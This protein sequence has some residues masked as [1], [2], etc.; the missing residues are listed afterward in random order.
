MERSKKELDAALEYGKEHGTAGVDY[1]QI[2]DAF[3][4]GIDWHK[5]QATT[6][7]DREYYGF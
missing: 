3:L 7:P 5:N 2:Y 6:K 1:D 4:A